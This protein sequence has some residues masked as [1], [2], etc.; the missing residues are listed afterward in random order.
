VVSLFGTELATQQAGPLKLR[1][2]SSETATA[3]R[4]VDQLSGFSASGRQRFGTPKVTA[5][6]TVLLA[7]HGEVRSRVGW[8]LTH[9]AFVVERSIDEACADAVANKLLSAADAATERE[10]LH[11]F[12]QR[13]RDWVKPRAAQVPAF[14]KALTG[15][16]S[17]LARFAKEAARFSGSPLK[18]VDVYL[19]P[20]S[21]GADGAYTAGRIVLEVPPE[22]TDDPLLHELWHAFAGSHLA[23]YQRAVQGKPRLDVET[24]SEGIAYA[25]QPGMYPAP[26]ARGALDLTVGSAMRSGEPSMLMGSTRP[27]E[28]AVALRGS[29][30]RAWASSTLDAFLPTA[31]GIFEALTE[32]DKSA[33]ATPR[34]LMLLGD[35]TPHRLPLKSQLRKFDAEQLKSTNLGDPVGFVL[36]GRGPEAVPQ[37]FREKYFDDWKAI[38][39]RLPEQA[40]TLVFAGHAPPVF[41]TWDR[42]PDS[43]ERVATHVREAL[44]QIIAAGVDRATLVEPAS[45]DG[46]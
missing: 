10:V 24:L 39:A 21:E 46:G 26:A 27:L 38:E 14:I 37:A 30:Q 15:D 17:R 5:D 41:I 28:L 4:L 40:A 23:Q 25:V 3:F 34:L 20:A 42:A 33:L 16:G 8:Q 19:V 31:A 12:E 22:P 13:A 1:F 45:R 7:R 36:V 29:L 43:K 18:S 44:F 6:E 9:S 35:D 2:L 32:L 11:A